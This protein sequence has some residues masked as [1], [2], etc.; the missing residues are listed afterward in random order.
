MKALYGEGIASRADPS[1]VLPG[2]ALTEKTRRLG[3]EP[4]R[5]TIQRRLEGSCPYFSAEQSLRTVDRTITTS[6][7]LEVT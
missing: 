1:H 3:I 7:I 6:K 4:Q 2:E 5:V